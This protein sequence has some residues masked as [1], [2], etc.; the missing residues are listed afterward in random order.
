MAPEHPPELVI[1]DSRFEE[2]I[3]KGDLCYIEVPVGQRLRVA[4]EPEHEP[5]NF[6]SVGG[7]VAYVFDTDDV[8]CRQVSHNAVPDDLGGFRYRWSEGLTPGIPWIMFV[9]ILPKDYTIVEPEPLPARAKTFQERLAL[10]WI[11]KGDDFGRTSVACTLKKFEG[12]AYSNLVQLNQI[13]SGENLPSNRYIQIEDDMLE[14]SL[15]QIQSVKTP[16][17]SGAIKAWYEKLGFLQEQ[18]ALT[19]DPAQKFALGKQ[20]QEAKTKIRELGDDHAGR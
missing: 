3:L 16:S 17:Q 2:G 7:G 12:D 10:Y 9:V 18:E 15:E 20:I 19:A 6:R 14:M 1:F 5:E 8:E 4:W 11:L 13:C